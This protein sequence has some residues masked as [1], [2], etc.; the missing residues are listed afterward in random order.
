M[1]QPFGRCF[2]RR[3]YENNLE[4]YIFNYKSFTSQNIIILLTMIVHSRT[5]IYFEQIK[6]QIL[7]LF[8]IS[9]S[10]YSNDIT[11]TKRHLY[12][13]FKVW[14][15]INQNELNRKISSIQLNSLG[16]ISILK[17]TSFK[18]NRN[19]RHSLSDRMIL[20]LKKVYKLL[21]NLFIII[22][23]YSF[24]GIY[25]VIKSRIRFLH[26]NHRYG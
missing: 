16:I 14:N 5:K 3:R 4:L 8:C 2:C 12:I 21:K 6:K 25:T 20:I 22:Y 10:V 15:F 26:N 24:L 1:K 7:Y 13:S 23:F 18:T 9:I 17:K 19:E 11:D